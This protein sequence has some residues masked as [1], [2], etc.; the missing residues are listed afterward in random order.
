MRRSGEEGIK[1]LM[2]P[3]LVISI[4][5]ILYIGLIVFESSRSNAQ[6]VVCTPKDHP[7]HYIFL[8][9]ID[10][11]DT[12][13]DNTPLSIKKKFQ[14]AHS[15]V[16]DTLLKGLF[17]IGFGKTDSGDTIPPYNNE[18]DFLTLLHFGIVRLY[19]KGESSYSR[20]KDN[21]D[22]FKEEYIR[23]ILTR[24]HITKDE[25]QHQL[26]QEDSSYTV[27][28][29]DEA[30]ALALGIVGT[31]IHNSINNRTFVIVVTGG[32]SSPYKKRFNFSESNQ[33]LDTI[34]NKYEF[35]AGREWQVTLHENATIFVKP[36]EVISTA[37][38]KWQDRVKNFS[39]F[40]E[41]STELE[42]E[43]GNETA[44]TLSVT[45]NDEFLKLLRSTNSALDSFGSLVVEG[46]GITSTPIKWDLYSK[47]KVSFK[48]SGILQCNQRKDYKVVLEVPINHIDN[49][50]GQRT[51][52]CKYEQVVTLPLPSRCTLWSKIWKAITLLVIT[53]LFV[54]L[55]YF[56]YFRFYSTHFKIELP[57]RLFPL[58]LKRHGKIKD[59]GALPPLEEEAIV[60]TLHLPKRW[61][62]HLFY[63]NAK[64][65][66][67]AS[68]NVSSVRWR[69]EKNK[70][71]SMLELPVKDKS[72]RS[73]SAVWGTISTE[74]TNIT[75][76]FRHRKISQTKPR[77]VLPFPKGQIGQ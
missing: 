68:N 18:K 66:L 27:M 50:L 14:E 37:Q 59:D 72:I 69:V 17:D 74:P 20:L 46:E 41:L 4:R 31:R 53:V 67:K 16:E 35:F 8:F 71:T 9:H 44:W 70:Y 5:L 64:L 6:I 57:G 61:L 62:Q 75:L 63:R 45:G 40:G 77:I 10:H 2:K 42:R 49:L 19:I 11:N 51:V 48:S 73:V 30:R 34:E 39:P 32:I 21:Y 24:I 22:F 28:S 55:L 60:L 23:E 29:W 56:S 25:L 58:P 65:E 52:I 36:Y 47:K 38:I 54:M 15:V 12:I 33:L 76:T 7:K 1:I 26:I 13:Y 43:S 3:C